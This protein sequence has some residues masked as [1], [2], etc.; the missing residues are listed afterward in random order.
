MY[1]TV[2]QELLHVP[3]T[4]AEAV[5]EPHAVGDDLRRKPVALVADRR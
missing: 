5:V 2:R 1:E 3:Q 4:Q